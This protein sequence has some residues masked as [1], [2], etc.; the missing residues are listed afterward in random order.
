MTGRAM[1]HISASL[2]RTRQLRPGRARQ[3]PVAE[4]PM[5]RRV[6]YRYGRQAPRYR[7]VVPAV[8][9]ALAQLFRIT[10]R[11]WLRTATSGRHSAGYVAAEPAGI[12][13]DT[14]AAAVKFINALIGEGSEAEVV[15][16]FGHADGSLTLAARLPRANAAL[17]NREPT[18][19]DQCHALDRFAAEAPPHRPISACSSCI[20]RGP[21]S[22]A[23]RIAELQ[24]LIERYPGMPLLG[25]Y[26][27]GQIAVF[28]QGNRQLQNT[29]VTALF[30][31]IRCSIPA[32]TRSGSS[33][34]PG[35]AS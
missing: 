18:A 32:V 33:S 16:P 25:T 8:W 12:L 28:G 21:I 30:T 7:W 31:E 6:S 13:A 11:H 34:A 22:T 27:T 15:A 10:A 26:G 20:G 5:Q 1:E 23:A 35:G 17:G 4:R 2:Q 19:A 14:S 9:L 3:Q 24:A 29:V